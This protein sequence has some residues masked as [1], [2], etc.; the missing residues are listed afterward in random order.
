MNLIRK[1][2]CDA[3]SE[4]IT[5]REDLIA[6]NLREIPDIERANSDCGFVTIRVTEQYDV[7]G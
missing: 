1:D 4:F 3:P 5:R 2:T 7:R 6:Q